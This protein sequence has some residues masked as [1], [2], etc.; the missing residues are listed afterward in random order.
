MSDRFSGS[1]EFPAAAMDGEI[2]SL[3]EEE[4]VEFEPLR[5]NYDISV[6]IEQG[7]FY[8]H[9][10][11]A[12]WGQFEELEAMLRRKGIP[13]DRDTSSYF[14]YTPE[15]VIFRPATN[16]N[17]AQDLTFAL[18]EGEPVIEVQTIRD[19]VPIGIEAIQAYLDEHFPFYPPLSD[20]VKE[21]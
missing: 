2:K 6:Q 3:L 12:N 1:I 4:G 16:G 10:P 11:E 5:A 7:L 17:P 21:G 18:S 14:D 15:R 19:L 20:F 9:N 13:F 8:M